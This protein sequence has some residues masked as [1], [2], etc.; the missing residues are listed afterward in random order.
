MID[1]ITETL[2]TKY[3]P[4]S[5]FEHDF[6]N[7]EFKE[8]KYLFEAVAGEIEPIL[9]SGRYDVDSYLGQGKIAGVPWV[10]IH[11]TKSGFPSAKTG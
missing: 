11:S 5:Q 8:L 9:P 6:S 4:T 7:E 3:F 1:K 2:S 10:G